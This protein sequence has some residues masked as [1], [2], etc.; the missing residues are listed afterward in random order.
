MGF[1]D[2]EGALNDRFCAAPNHHLIAAGQA[3]R[4]PGY[5]LANDC[6]PLLRSGNQ[7]RT[8][9]LEDLSTLPAGRWQGVGRA[10]MQAVEEWAKADPIRYVFRYANQREA[11]LVY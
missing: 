3:E 8:M 5:A 10:L 9:K 2:D 6:D 7:H 11:G 4:L 1:V